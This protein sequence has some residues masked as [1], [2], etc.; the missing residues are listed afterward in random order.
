MSTSALVR[1]GRTAN[2]PALFTLP[3]KFFALGL[4]IGFLSLAYL[5]I[6]LWMIRTGQMPPW[7]DYS[8]RRELHSYSALFAFLGVGILGFAL[9][10][11]PRLLGVAITPN[12]QLLLIAFLPLIGTVVAFFTEYALLGRLLVSAAF[13]LTA[14]RTVYYLCYGERDALL[15]HG[16]FLL[17]ALIFLGIGALHGV[18][19][20]AW[21]VAAFWGGVCGAVFAA[22]QQFLFVFLRAK[23]LSPRWAITV[24]LLYLSSA[25]GGVVAVQLNASTIWQLS[26]LGVL[27][28][29]LLYL[30]ATG[31]FAA[32]RRQGATAAGMAFG[33]A[34]LWAIVGGVFLLAGM[35]FADNAL[36]AWATGWVVPLFYF[37]SSHI[38]AVHAGRTSLAE[39][40]SLIVLW[41]LVPLGRAIPGLPPWFSWIV[42]VVATVLLTW[43]CFFVVRCA[44]LALARQLAVAVSPVALLSRV[45]DSGGA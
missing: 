38:V 6:H 22:W 2:K 29:I 25:C 3:D 7:H 4:I 45:E 5:G 13:F 19:I 24:L 17:S 40:R 10:A 26:S 14:V 21:G 33:L 8:W 16:V 37:V 43:W 41:Q 36:H 34:A 31:S 42:A 27:A 30:Q 28:T 32:F 18:D 44:S 15:A 11:G 12:P 9:Q 1:I 39:R 35:N 23:K 20:A